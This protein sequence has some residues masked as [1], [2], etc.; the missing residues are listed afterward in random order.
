M[1][2]LIRKYEK[3]LKELYIISKDIWFQAKLNDEQKVI[4]Y[5]M[6]D[7]LQNTI[8]ELNLVYNIKI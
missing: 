6:I 7:N 2:T 1:I 8:N 3:L 4:H 5:D